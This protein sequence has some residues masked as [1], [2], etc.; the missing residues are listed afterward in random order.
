MNVL[1]SA[2]L[3]GLCT[4]YDGCSQPQDLSKLAGH[5][6]IPVCPEQ[7]GGLSTPRPPAE[8]QPDGRVITAQG[9]DVTGHYQHGA[10]QALHVYKACGCK[11]ALLKARSP[12]CGVGQVYDGTFSGTLTSG[13]GV[14]VQLLKRQGMAVFTEHEMDDLLAY[15]H[16]KEDTGV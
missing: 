1:I 8:I 15:I 6:L 4:R 13:D 9:V 12:S 7:L 5:V 10:Q 16:N 2:C 11:A 14:S 3:M